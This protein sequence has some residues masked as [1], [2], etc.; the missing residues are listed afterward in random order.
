MGTNASHPGFMKP[1]FTYNELI[2]QALRDKG[3]LTASG[4]YKWIS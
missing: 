1:P 3:E 4:I 2:E